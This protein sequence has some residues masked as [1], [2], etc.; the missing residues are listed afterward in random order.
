MKNTVQLSVPH[1]TRLLQ[2]IE[3]TFFNLT[4]PFLCSIPCTMQH[5]DLRI[6][7]LPLQER[8]DGIHLIDIQV[9][10]HRQRYEV[11]DRRIPHHGRID[12]GVISAQPLRATFDD[13]T[14]FVTLDSNVGTKLQHPFDLDP[15]GAE[16]LRRLLRRY[17]SHSYVALPDSCCT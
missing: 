1:S 17:M 10:Y 5:V 9:T 2:A 11:P 7:Q 4:Y 15:A 13:L 8:C 16:P 14:S 12:F 3:S 6:V